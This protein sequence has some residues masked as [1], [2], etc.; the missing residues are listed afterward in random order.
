LA[1]L[2]SVRA[3][4]FDDNHLIQH[5]LTFVGKNQYR[6]VA[7]V[8]RDFHAA[9]LHA[10]PGNTLTRID[11]LTIGRA[12]ICYAEIPPGAHMQCALCVSAARHGKLPVLQYLRSMNCQWDESTCTVA[13]R[14][15]HL[16]I[17]K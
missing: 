13:A 9:Y 17:L 7:A 1:A 5:I 3:S 6:F 11:L 14:N 8:N 10:F 4:V 16:H 12:T 2:V 15:C